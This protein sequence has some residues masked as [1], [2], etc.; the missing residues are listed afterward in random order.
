[1]YVTCRA[2]DISVYTNAV[3]VRSNDVLIT[4]LCCPRIFR[5]IYTGASHRVGPGGGV[6][7]ERFHSAGKLPVVEPGGSGD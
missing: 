6:L 3:L 2:S 4:T 5:Y 7:E 1:M